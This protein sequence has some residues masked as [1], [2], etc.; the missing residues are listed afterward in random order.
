MLKNAC[1]CL[2]FHYDYKKNKVI[3]SVFMLMLIIKIRLI[4]NYQLG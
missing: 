3:D 2:Q 4:S 1:K